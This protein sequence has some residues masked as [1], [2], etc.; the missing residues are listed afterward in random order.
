MSHPTDP[1]RSVLLPLAMICTVTGV[2]LT[3][4]AVRHTQRIPSYTPQMYQNTPNQLT[5]QRPGFV[6]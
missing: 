6:R 4:M 3:M 2:F 1:K 5:P